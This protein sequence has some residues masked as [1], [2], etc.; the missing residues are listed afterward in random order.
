M[1]QRPNTKG[2]VSRIFRV[3]IIAVRIIGIQSEEIRTVEREVLNKRDPTKYVRA[4]T[5]LYP[6]EMILRCDI[7]SD[8][9]VLRVMTPEEYYYNS[10]E[11][12]FKN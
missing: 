6:G 8:R 9:R 7:I 1:N 5:I 11:I 2:L 4:T 12:N 3:T 10:R